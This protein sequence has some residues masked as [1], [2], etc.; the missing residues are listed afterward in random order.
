MPRGPARSSNSCAVQSGAAKLGDDGISRVILTHFL[1]LMPMLFAAAAGE[2]DP[3]RTMARRMVIR[4][5]MILR[6]PVR[7]RPGLPLEWRERRGP[8]CVAATTIAGAMLSSQDS[9][10][11]ALRDRGRLRAELD[12][13]CLALDF[14]GGFYVEPSDGR[15]CARRDAIRSRMGGSCR[16]IRFRELVPHSKP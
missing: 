1:T 13:D 16:I 10:D 14:Y 7:A 11:F 15:L 6:I 8:R 2:P 3:E 4:D 12:K 5:A 9:V